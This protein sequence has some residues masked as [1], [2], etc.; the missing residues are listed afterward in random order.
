MS[1]LR[2]RAWSLDPDDPRAPT[3]AM[4][5]EMSEEERALVAA[6]LPSE[7]EAVPEGDPHRIAK[8]QALDPLQ[9][10][11]ERIGRRVYLSSELPVYYPGEPVFAPDLIA[12][13][14][15]D[16][17][18]RDKWLVQAEG[19]G[20]DLALEVNVGGDRRKDLERNVEWFA[21]LGIPEYFVYEPLRSVLRGFALVPGSRSYRPMLGQAGRFS[22]S[23]LG[24][25]L[26]IEQGRLRFFYGGASVPETRELL[27]RANL[28][29]SEIS[30]K[31]EEALRA[32]EEAARRAEEEARLRAEEARRADEAERRLAEAL[33]EIERLRRG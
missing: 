6:A 15:A 30:G 33:A 29:V 5:D 28:L 10:F 8:Q 18:P 4:W 23:A 17:R 12:V 7:I 2:V 26:G 19:R 13:V 31:Y 32:G 25:D 3:A 22:S 14:D 20:I 9:G 21:R 16:V 27:E 24:L 11:F 1:V